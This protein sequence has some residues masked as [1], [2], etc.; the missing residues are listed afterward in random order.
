MRG[1][2][3]KPL[4]T[5]DGAGR[6]GA[7]LPRVVRDFDGSLPHGC[8]GPRETFHHAGYRAAEF[9]GVLIHGVLPSLLVQTLGFLRRSQL[10]IFDRL[11]AEYLQCTG[12][13]ADFVSAVAIGNFR[14]RVAGREF[15]HSTRH[16][17][18]WAADGACD[19]YRENDADDGC[20]SR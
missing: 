15:G 20:R 10:V 6:S 4:P 3:R 5:S 17:M 12:H 11:L 14:R 9:L 18:D 13:F 19:Q 16:A 7:G 2:W 1:P 8:S